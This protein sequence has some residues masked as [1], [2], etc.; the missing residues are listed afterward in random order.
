MKPLFFILFL[1]G[2]FLFSSIC[3]QGAM[4]PSVPFC[5]NQGYTAEQINDKIYCVFDDGNK[6]EIWSFFRGECGVEYVKEFPCKP[7]GEIVFKF[8]ECCEGK[9]YLPPMHVGQTSCTPFSERLKGNLKYSPLHW[10][11]ILVI[12]VLIIIG[13]LKISKRVRGK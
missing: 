1:I 11:G 8:E 3:V 13:V 6:C 5:K 4:E 12:V 9:P 7:L 2:I 10:F